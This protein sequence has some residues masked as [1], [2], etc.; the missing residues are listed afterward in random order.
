MAQMTQIT[1]FVLCSSLDRQIEFYR[2]RLGFAL[3]FRADNY[4]FLRRDSVAVRLLECPPRDDGRPLGDDQSFYIDVKGIDALF[5]SLKPGLDDLPEGRVRPP[6]DQPYMQ[7]EFHVLDED[8]T[9][10]FFGEGV[11]DRS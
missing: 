10:V 9:L 7:R 6:F 11:G 2:D 3:G 8:G 5:E 1:P 4:A